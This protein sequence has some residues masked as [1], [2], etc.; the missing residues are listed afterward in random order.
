MGGSEK[1]DKTAARGNNVE[2]SGAMARLAALTRATPAA[3]PEDDS[4][5]D[6]SASRSRS[7]RADELAEARCSGHTTTHRGHDGRDCITDASL[8]LLV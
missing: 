2:R 4:A 6:R 3:E 5:S 7:E 8:Q 1:R